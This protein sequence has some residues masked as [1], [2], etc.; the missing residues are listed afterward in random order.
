[1]PPAERC[2]CREAPAKNEGQGAGGLGSWLRGLT[3]K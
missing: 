2:R 1:M 3:K